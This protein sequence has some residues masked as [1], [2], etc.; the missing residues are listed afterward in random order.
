MADDKLTFEEF[1]EKEYLPL[2]DKIISLE[3]KLNQAEKSLAA[4]KLNSS[5]SNGIEELQTELSKLR[6]EFEAQRAVSTVQAGGKAKKDN[7]VPV[8]EDTFKVGKVTYQFTVG[9]Y[10]N[11]EGNRVNTA[12]ILDDKAELERLIAIKSGIIKV[13]K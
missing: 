4:A 6:E 1:Y 10:I 12:T 8:P 7:K 11:A 3:E 13:V 2:Q 9:Q 5:N